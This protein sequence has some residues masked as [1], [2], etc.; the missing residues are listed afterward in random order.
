MFELHVSLLTRPLFLYNEWPHVITSILAITNVLIMYPSLYY[1]DN[2]MLNIYT[3]CVITVD[4]FSATIQ[5]MKGLNDN[6]PSELKMTR[7]LLQ[8]NLL[9]MDF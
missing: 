4:C 3:S 5:L 9:M 6:L 1:S 7:V 8:Y 2:F